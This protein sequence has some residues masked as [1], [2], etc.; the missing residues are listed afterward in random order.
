M[1]FGFLNFI[2]VGGSKNVLTT[3]RALFSPEF[4]PTVA[5]FDQYQAYHEY[6]NDELMVVETYFD[7][8]PNLS[9]SDRN[10]YDMF[11]EKQL[12]EKNRSSCPSFYILWLRSKFP[13]DKK[14][15]IKEQKEIDI[16]ENGI[17]HVEY[18]IVTQTDILKLYVSDSPVNLP[19]RGNACLFEANGKSI[20]E[21]Y[22]KD[23]AGG[24]MDETVER[25]L[26]NRKLFPSGCKVIEAAD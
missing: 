9:A 5:L 10:V 16:V 22:E 4:C 19:L 1:G 2:A 17:H 13:Y 21:E 7:H 20:S 15:K 25:F 11:Y 6:I 26:R 3:Y 18:T 23:V 12:E 14:T 24:K 8:H